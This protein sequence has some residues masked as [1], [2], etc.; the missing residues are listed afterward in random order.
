MLGKSLAER[1]WQAHAP[2]HYNAPYR[3]GLPDYQGR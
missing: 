1:T 2:S 3:E